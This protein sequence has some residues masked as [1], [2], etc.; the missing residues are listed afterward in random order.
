[1]TF[2]FGSLIIVDSGPAMRAFSRSIAALFFL[3]SLSFCREA[4]PPSFE[5][6]TYRIDAGIGKDSTFR[7]EIR[8][9]RK[10]LDSSMEQV[11]GRSAE[12]LKTGRPE[13][14]LG[15]LIADL[16]KE[17]SERWSEKEGFPKPDLVVL[18]NGGLRQPLPEGEITQRRIF[19]LMPFENIVEWVKLDGEAMEGLFEY[20]AETPQPISGARFRIDEG[21]AKDREVAGSPFDPG[22]SYWVVSSDFLIEGGDGMNFFEQAQERRS[23]GIKL[24]DM[25]LHGIRERTEQGEVLKAELDGRIREKEL[26][27]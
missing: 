13:G 4:P 8:P 22:R 6:E 15:N 12:K 7:E 26:G 9:Y 27:T 11:V 21:Q 17:R 2:R 10:R 20:L 3:F 1:M 16:I 24:R 18:N 19:Q 5:S 25:I 23:S 14:K